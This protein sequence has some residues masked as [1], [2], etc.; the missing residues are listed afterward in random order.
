MFNKRI[1]GHV[2]HP[3][4]FVWRSGREDQTIWLVSS[5]TIH[6][7][8]CPQPHGQLNSFAVSLWTALPTKPSP[9]RYFRHLSLQLTCHTLPGGAPSLLTMA[10]DLPQLH[11]ANRLALLCKAH[12]SPST[13]QLCLTMICTHTH[14][15]HSVS[16]RLQGRGSGSSPNGLE[17]MGCSDRWGGGHEK[18]SSQYRC[19]YSHKEKWDSCPWGKVRR[20]GWLPMGNG[21]TSLKRG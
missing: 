16:E 11:H 17:E 7:F 2:A 1:W 9:T 19:C 10:Q 8:L 21:N 15:F 20:R 5:M 12:K 14:C 3:R 4:F 13:R 6:V 18:D